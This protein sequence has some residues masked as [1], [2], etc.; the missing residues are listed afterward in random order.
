MKVIKSSEGI[1]A[2]KPDGTEVIYHIFPEYEIHYNEVPPQTTQQWHYHKI[3][4]EIVC[5]VS[6]EIELHWI[7]DGKRFSS[8]LYAGDIVRVENTPHTFINS[9]PTTTTF[10]VFRLILNGKDVREI[11]KSDKYL[12]KP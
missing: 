1:F 5:I 2:R 6:G 10:L 11:I 4:E 9:S 12:I 8:T 3:I 7:A